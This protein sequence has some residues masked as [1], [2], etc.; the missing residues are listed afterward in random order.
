MTAEVVPARLGHVLALVRQL[1]AQEFAGKDLDP[2][3][4]MARNFAE[5]RK[6]K[7]LLID[8]HVVAAYGLVGPLLASEAFIWL[9]VAPTI[10]HHAKAFIAACRDEFAAISVSEGALVAWVVASDP[11]ALRFAQRWGFRLG[12]EQRGLRRGVLQL[13]GRKVA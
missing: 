2:R 11:V 8:G 5:S 9:M 4:L 6:A 1:D 3:R 7:V 12:E 10:R 13:S